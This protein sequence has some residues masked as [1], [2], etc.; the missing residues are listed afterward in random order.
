MVRSI[1]VVEGRLKS[2]ALSGESSESG[3]KMIQEMVVEMCNSIQ[4]LIAD[5]KYLLMQG[6]H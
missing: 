5:L 3:E 4:T 6:L 1:P 2:M